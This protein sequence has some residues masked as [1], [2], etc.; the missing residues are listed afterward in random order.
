[1]SGFIPYGRQQISEEDIEAVVRV[2]RSDYL[3]Q[4]PAVPAFEHAVARYCGAAHAVAMN[5]ATSALHV[6]CLA[7]G[8]GPG[9]RVWTSPVTFVASANCALYCGA[10]V[11]F[12]DVDPATGNMSTDH[13]AVK[14][15]QAE[16]DGTLPK[17]VIPVH[18]CGRSCDMK[19][20]R[21]LSRRFGFAVIEDASHAIGARYDGAPVGDCRYSDI[22]VFSFHP[23]KIITTA[24]GGMAMTQDA[25]LARR[26]ER[27]RSHG[28]TR[29]PADMTHEPDG[30]WYYQ[31]IDLGF[32][33]RMT[34]MQAALGLS[35]MSRL[36]AFV[37][38]RYR[39]AARY[40][41]A[42]AA[43]P[44]SLPPAEPE[45]RSALH[46]YVVQVGAGHDRRTVFEAL[47]A[48]D[49]GVNVHYIPV[50]LQPYY[51]ALG[52]RPGHCPDAERYYAGA[53]SL[54]MHPGLSEADQDRVIG[55]LRDALA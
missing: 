43:L 2:L 22:T 19:T 6:A 52:F 26:M 34:D 10:A 7:L 31:Q 47:R 20:V 9:D 36:D 41:E 4:G 17:V 55:A 54:P 42:L 53:I 3:T 46:L 27:L 13:L 51:A 25:A 39:V 38:R 14:L 8:V 45:G 5:S 23:V 24:E 32:N 33:Y 28:I 30:P 1:M 21:A 16:R 48:R 15:A 49:I 37:D 11:D 35:Q 50:H 44:L 29:D 12:V 18:L 40:A